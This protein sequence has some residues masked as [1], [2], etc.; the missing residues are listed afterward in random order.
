M[1]IDD[2][3]TLMLD[4]GMV[5]GDDL[6]AT[7]RANVP[8]LPSGR[9]TLNLV[10]TSVAGPLRTNNSVITPAY[11]NVGAQFSARADTPAAARAK[12][13]AAYNQVVGVRNAWV[14]R[15]GG[16]FSGWYREINPLQEPFEVPSG[17]DDRGKARFVFSVVAIR[18][19]DANA[20]PITLHSSWIQ[21]EWAS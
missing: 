18:R 19:T 9:A 21:E 6:Y 17:P 4:A 10:E 8:H 5:L 1:W 16:G 12:A 3:I 15:S 11:I 20:G 14:V 7:T 13:Y 2:L